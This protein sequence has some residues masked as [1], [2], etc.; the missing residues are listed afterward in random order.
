MVLVAR[1]MVQQAAYLIM[2][3][4]TANLDYGN[5]I[6][7]LQAIRYLSEEE[8]GI[9]MTSHNPDHAFLACS[10]TLLMRDGYVVCSGPPEETVTTETLTKLYATPVAV[11]PTEAFGRQ[12]KACIPLMDSETVQEDVLGHGPCQGVSAERQE[13]RSTCP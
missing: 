12:F 4:P 7:V 11:S 8:Y 6:R 5:Q 2:D 9:L 1:A 3:E 10:R 13:R